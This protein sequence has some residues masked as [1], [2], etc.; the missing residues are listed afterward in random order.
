[1]TQLPIH[2]DAREAAPRARGFDNSLALL[3]EGYRFVSRRCE[4]LGSD[5][6]ATR[7]L[8]RRVLCVRGEAAARMFYQPG[9]FTRRRALPST[10]LTLLQDTGSVLSLDGDMHRKRKAMLMSLFG[11]TERQRLVALAAAGWRARF[12]QWP[13]ASSVN[14]HEAAQEV[15]CEAA[16]R[17][18]GIPLGPGDAARRTAEFAA[19]IRAPSARCGC[20]RRAR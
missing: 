9:R 16:C 10:A 17:W 1:V 18:A 2:A 11:P 5:V 7:L 6:F 20:G 3:A 12:A 19:M 15:L 13:Q 4:A 8:L 14:L